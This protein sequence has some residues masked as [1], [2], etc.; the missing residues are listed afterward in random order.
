VRELWPVP[1]EDVDLEAAYAVGVRRSAPGD[2]PWVVVNMIA[3]VDGAVAVDGRSGGLGGPGDKAV[4]RALRALPD[5]I[6]VGATTVR[7]ERYGPPRT[8]E[9]VRD[10]RRARG[11][12]PA[13][14]LVVVSGSLDLDPELGLFADAE[15]APMVVTGAAADRARAERLA[16]V[17]EVV[18]L[19]GD[20]VGPLALLA[21]LAATG[22]GVVLCEGGPSLNGQ[23]LAAGVVDEWCTTLAPLLVAG[24]AGRVA[25]GAP[26]EVPERLALHQ[27]LGD[28]EGYLFLRY[29]TVR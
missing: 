14:R 21:H 10:A 18:R 7:E 11:Q 8:S 29:L 26:L 6:V 23:M 15:V 9:A 20:R 12:T 16:E 24:A 22:A 2:R 4:F 17:A 27:V 28:D 3:S 13:P 25:T 1:A 19:P 5:V